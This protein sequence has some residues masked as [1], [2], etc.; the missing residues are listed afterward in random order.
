[1]EAGPARAIGAAER[2]ATVTGSL[3]NANV[4]INTVQRVSVVGT[5]GAGKSTVAA[6]LA[7][8]LGASFLELDSVQHF[9]GFQ[10]AYFKSQKHLRSRSTKFASR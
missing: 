5:S 8:L 6:A 2:R 7:A 1:M 10:I 3:H 9:A 4:G